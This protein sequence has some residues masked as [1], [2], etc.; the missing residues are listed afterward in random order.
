MLCVKKIAITIMGLSVSGIASAAMYVPTAAACSGINATVPCAQQGWELGVQALYAQ[1]N[2]LQSVVVTADGSPPGE[3]GVAP[4]RTNNNR[5]NFNLNSPWGWGYRL[6]GGYHFGT[7]TDL[8]LNWTSLHR[9]SNTAQ[10]DSVNGLVPAFIPVISFTTG[11][12]DPGFFQNV[13]TSMENDYDAVNLE[14]GQLVNFGEHINVRFHAGVQFAQIN[15]KITQSAWQADPTN[16]FQDTSTDRFKGA[17]P[18]VGMDGE[19]MIH[20]GFS[21]VGKA[22]VAL[23]YGHTNFSSTENH[24]VNISGVEVNVDQNVLN[25]GQQVLVPSAEAKLGVKYAHPMSKG[26][27]N[28]EAGYQ[29]ANYWGPFN[30]AL[31][32]TNVNDN[33]AY[34]GVYA[35]LSWLGA[36]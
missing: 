8:N 32:N 12:G 2:P 6:E 25:S 29:V 15:Q 30:N 23:L 4:I 36:V 3:N 7:G 27:L 31:I 20:S 26:I 24:F 5:Q 16:F 18:R 21:L 33:F 28:V 9:S 14:L 17:G 13:T 35:G 1:I 22:A 34:N 11:L 10:S 19:Y